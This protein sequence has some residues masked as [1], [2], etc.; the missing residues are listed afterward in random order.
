MIARSASAVPFSNTALRYHNA[1]TVVF[2]GMWRFLTMM[3]VN[4]INW[5]RCHP[6]ETDA[7]EKKNHN[8]SNK[9]IN[10]IILTSSK[11]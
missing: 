2:C 6:I 1:G 9:L 7:K 11:Y 8:G 3:E 10:S 4:L 5:K